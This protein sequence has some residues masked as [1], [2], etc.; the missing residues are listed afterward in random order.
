MIILAGG[1]VAVATNSKN[2]LTGSL[3]ELDLSSK[4]GMSNKTTK[5]ISTLQLISTVLFAILSE[6]IRKAN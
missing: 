6:L 2:L 5:E 1:S 3:I 4:S